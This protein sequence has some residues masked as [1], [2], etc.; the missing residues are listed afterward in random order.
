[1]GTLITASVLLVHSAQSFYRPVEHL[2]SSSGN[3]STDGS[4][5]NLGD[6]PPKRLLETRGAE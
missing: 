5:P 2:D 1:L 6:M 4:E 3:G